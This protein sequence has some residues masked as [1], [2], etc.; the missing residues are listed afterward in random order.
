MMRKGFNQFHWDDKVQDLLRTDRRDIIMPIDPPHPC[1]Q[2][3]LGASKREAAGTAEEFQGKLVYYQQ[4]MAQF[5]KTSFIFIDI[6]QWLRFNNF[7]DTLSK[8]VSQ[9]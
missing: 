7:K 4:Q 5:I 8:S 1:L 2:Q 3:V 6:P 9:T